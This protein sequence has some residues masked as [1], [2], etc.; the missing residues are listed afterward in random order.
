MRVPS[1]ISIEYWTGDEWVAVTPTNE[2]DTFTPSVANEY[3]F[4]EVTTTK[5]RLTMNNRTIN[6]VTYALAIY[7]WE[8]IQ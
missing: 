3:L 1:G 6:N 5:I 7:E 4:E 8:L 2:W